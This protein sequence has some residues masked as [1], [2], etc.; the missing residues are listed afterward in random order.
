M[1]HWIQSVVD[2][3]KTTSPKR[4]TE[5]FD[6][7]KSI[8]ERADRERE[9]LEKWKKDL[10]KM[11]DHTTELDTNHYYNHVLGA[12]AIA[13]NITYGEISV[14]DNTKTTLKVDGTIEAQGRD[15][16]KELDEMRD[17]LLLL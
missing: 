6:Y 7:R 5:Y 16:L 4:G 8:R 10:R 14:A 9:Y 17:A 2:R 11:R 13:S 3:W 12:S 1:R 15:I